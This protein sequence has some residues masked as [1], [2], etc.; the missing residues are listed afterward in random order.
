MHLTL[1]WRHCYGKSA[2]PVCIEVCN[3]QIHGPLVILEQ[4]ADA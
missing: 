3:W 2:S 1:G 4:M